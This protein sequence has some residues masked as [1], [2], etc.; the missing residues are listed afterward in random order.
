MIRGTVLTFFILLFFGFLRPG[1]AQDSL[2]NDTVDSLAIYYFQVLTDT[3]HKYRFGHWCTIY[4]VQPEGRLAIIYLSDRLDSSAV[5]QALHADHPVG[6]IYAMEAMLKWSRDQRVRLT[7]EDRKRMKLIL[8]KTKKVE[9]CYG[10]IGDYERIPQF[11]DP[12]LLKIL[13]DSGP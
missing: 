10:C 12:E 3:A 4:G 6:R 11:L 1:M 13:K 9:T 5:R 8:R 2:A 7:A